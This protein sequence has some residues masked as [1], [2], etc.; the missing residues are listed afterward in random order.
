MLHLVHLI[1]RCKTCGKKITKGWDLKF[2]KQC[3]CS[4]K[5]L[6][7][8]LLSPLLSSL[9]PH[10][11]PP[12]PVVTGSLSSFSSP[13]I[14]AHHHPPTYVAAFSVNY[15][16]IIKWTMKLQECLISSKPEF[17]IIL[18]FLLLADDTTSS[19]FG[20]CFQVVHIIYKFDQW[21]CFR[22]RWI[23]FLVIVFSGDGFVCDGDNDTAM[24]GIGESDD[25][26][27]HWEGSDWRWWEEKRRFRS[28]Y[29][30]RGEWRK[31]NCIFPFFY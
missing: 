13:P 24:K 5:I 6:D 12:F 2:K 27:I 25:V 19:S 15:D 8:Y 22:R 20:Y 28:R 14:A 21:D 17:F 1:F 26:V 18:R 4:I 16:I 10:S 9:S 30:E 29:W 31:R 3:I 7:L 11:P 23:C